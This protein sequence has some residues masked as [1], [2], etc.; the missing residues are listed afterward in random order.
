MCPPRQCCCCLIYQGVKIWTIVFICLNALGCVGM[1]GLHFGFSEFWCG[2]PE[3]DLC[4]DTGSDC[5]ANVY[6]N[7][8]QE[9]EAAS[10]VAG[11]EP[12]TQ[13]ISYDECPNYKCVAIGSAKTDYE[14]KPLVADADSGHCLGITLSA[15]IGYAVTAGIMVWGLL[16][17]QSF[18]GVRVRSFGYTVIFMSSLRAVLDLAGGTGFTSVVFGFALT[19]WYACA[20][21]SLSKQMLDGTITQDNP[22]GTPQAM[23][24]SAIAQP[25]QP[26]AA[27]AMAVPVQAMAV[28]V[29]AK[30]VAV[31]MQQPVAVAAGQPVPV[32]VAAVTAVNP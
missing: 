17:I 30:A 27:M 19:M 2:L 8:W 7:D 28:P 25:A 13:P 12:T 24:M 20:V 14:G 18:N 15:F 5:C 29:Q 32:P 26:V 22:T 9:A 23:T 3:N 31:P 16:G 1:L 21:I 10:C 11:Y 6:G 4:R